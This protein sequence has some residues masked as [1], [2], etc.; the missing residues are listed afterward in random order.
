MQGS[1]GAL[2]ETIRNSKL[3]QRYSTG[4]TLKSQSFRRGKSKES[5]RLY[6][7]PRVPNKHRDETSCR[8][9]DSWYWIPESHAEWRLCACKCKYWKL[10]NNNII[11]YIQF[12]AWKYYC[13]SWLLILLKFVNTYLVTFFRAN[14]G[15]SFGPSPSSRPGTDFFS[16][17]MNWRSFDLVLEK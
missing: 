11:T 8:F 16:V 9:P 3:K 4:L 15:T 1:S 13:D 7:G 12:Y 10:K 5:H 14:R 17:K 2:A 6:Y